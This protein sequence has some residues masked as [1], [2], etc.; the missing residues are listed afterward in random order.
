VARASYSLN[1]YVG[2]ATPALV[3]GT[4]TSSSTTIT[5]SGTSAAW[6]TLGSTGGWF[7]ALNYGSI[8]EEKVY[9][10]SGLYSWSSGVVTL[11]GVVRGVDGTTASGFTGVK[12]VAP[13]LTAIDLQEANF[14]V[15]TLLGNIA[16]VSGQAILS[17]GTTLTFGTVSVSG[18]AVGGALSG[19]L[20]NP[21][22]ASGVSLN[23]PV[24][25]SGTQNYVTINSGTVNTPNVGDNSTSIAN[26]F[27]VSELEI[28]TI[29]GALN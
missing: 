23:F 13:V 26:T 4:I 27:F 5:I 22:I 19:Y 1:S 12:F 17:N 25:T 2:G 20:P 11:S 24:I 3:S 8:N 6:G 15:N 29:M 21:T 28:L 10:P 9:V 14:L 16:V 7:G 18:T